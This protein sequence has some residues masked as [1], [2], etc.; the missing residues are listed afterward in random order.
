MTLSI[1]LGGRS[2]G[3]FPSSSSSSPRQ[4]STHL[5]SATSLKHSLLLA[6]W[7]APPC[8]PESAPKSLPSLWRLPPAHGFPCHVPGDGRPTHIH[9][10]LVDMSSGT[11]GRPFKLFIFPCPNTRDMVT[12]SLQEHHIQSTRKP[13]G[14]AVQN[15]PSDLRVRHHRQPTPSSSPARTAVINS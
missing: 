15:R 11:Q 12:P 4:P 1:P 8:K 13:W 5:I 3:R 10:C 14:L 2:R 9:N 6:S 7:P